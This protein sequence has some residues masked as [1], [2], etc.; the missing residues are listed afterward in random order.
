MRL[1]RSDLSAEGICRRRRGKGFTYHLNGSAVG[2]AETLARIRALV[3]PPAWQQVWICPDPAGHIQAVGVDVAGRKQ[4]LYHEKWR[5]K[6]DA[7][8]FE[9]MLEVARA[10]PR[11]RKRVAADLDGEGVP[12]E[13]ALAAATRL[14]DSAALR[15]GGESYAQDDPVLGEATFGLATL[16][17]EHVI[18][19][20][21]RI[22]FRFA[23]K[24]GGTLEFDV[25]DAALA[26]VLTSLLRR[27]DANP[28]LLAY[29]E[30]RGWRDVRSEHVNEYLR[31]RSGLEMT[32]KDFRT[33]FGTVAAAMSL[34][35]SG[36][37]RG[38]THE[39]RVI[40]QAMR[41]TAELLGNTPAIARKSY[42]DAR[43]LELYRSG[44]IIRPGL[45]RQQAERAVSRLLTNA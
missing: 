39:R 26:R 10:L 22:S 1:R 25:D 43:V 21:E 12:R 18:V 41:D 34:A 27:R 32:A 17:R 44:V 11:L 33:W 19:R 5:T 8:K 4:Y 35:E 42:V 6:R 15:I 7:E 38:V 16:R 37:A 14:L 40:A 45:S 2:D 13:R 23:G 3:I 24:G 31:D 29:R 28:E 36:L 9:H 20:G 30:G